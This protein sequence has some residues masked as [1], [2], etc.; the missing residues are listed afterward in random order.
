[1][2]T[3]VKVCGAAVPVVPA[4]AKPDESMLIVKVAPVVALTTP[5]RPLISGMPVTTPNTTKSP[6]LSVLVA[7]TTAFA[8]GAPNSRLRMDGR[9]GADSAAGN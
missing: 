5:Y 1:M 8:A 2:A 3:G 4:L 9:P 6:T 7:V